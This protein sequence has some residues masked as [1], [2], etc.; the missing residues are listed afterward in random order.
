MLKVS[1]KKDALARNS[2]RMLKPM[3]SEAWSRFALDTEQ[4]PVGL[5]GFHWHLQLLL[6]ASRNLGNKAKQD[7]TGLIAS[8]PSL[9]PGRE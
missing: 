3:A 7:M 6:H 4:A 8:M 5:L 9:D 2:R 1:G